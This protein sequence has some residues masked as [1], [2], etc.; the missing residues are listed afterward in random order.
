[1][2]KNKINTYLGKPTADQKKAIRKMMSYGDMNLRDA[3]ML[4]MG[5]YDDIFFNEKKPP[6]TNK[7]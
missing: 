3:T 7:G 6:S 4:V 5:T 2:A 1:M